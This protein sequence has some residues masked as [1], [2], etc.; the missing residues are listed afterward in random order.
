MQLEKNT[1]LEESR[2]IICPLDCSQKTNLDPIQIC[3]WQ[4]CGI[5]S[6]SHQASA[7]EMPV[8]ATTG[9]IKAL[10]EKAVSNFSLV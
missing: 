1:M 2:L 10:W 3:I 8:T 7:A 6:F 5:V 9:F 4:S